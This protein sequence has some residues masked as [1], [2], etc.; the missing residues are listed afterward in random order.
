MRT[1]TK[2]V[3]LNVGLQLFPLS[4]TQ[5]VL[6]ARGAFSLVLLSPAQSLSRQPQAVSGRPQIRLLIMQTLSSTHF[7]LVKS[8]RV[9]GPEVLTQMYCQ[10][11]MT[12]SLVLSQSQEL[13]LQL[14]FL[15]LQ[16]VLLLC[17]LPPFTCEP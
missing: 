6:K 13:V 15:G 9:R 8:R 16:S 7:S 14:S 10:R 3:A 11:S 1:L 17:S 12:I 2:L 4:A 5:D